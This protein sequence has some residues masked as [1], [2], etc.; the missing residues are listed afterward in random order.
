MLAPSPPPAVLVAAMLPVESPWSWVSVAALVAALSFLAWAQSA[1]PRFLVAMALAFLVGAG[2]IATDR[3][4]VTDR[5]WIET[6]FLRLAQAAEEGDDATILAAF[7]PEAHEVRDA[8]AEILAQFTAEEVRITTMEVDVP[9]G[10]A[11]TTAR[12]TFLVR[13]RGTLRGS[14]PVNG[15][16]DFDVTLHKD[17]D[18]W[19]IADFEIPE[20]RRFERR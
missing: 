7:A 19:L 5:E 2:A 6:M 8:A 17:G 15:L 9:A 1:D 10:N 13:T 4:V 11:A 14:T 16:I 12:A 18:R 3:L 20:G